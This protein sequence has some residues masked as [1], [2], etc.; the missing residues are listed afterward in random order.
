MA[1]HL[2]TEQD[3]GLE[4]ILGQRFMQRWGAYDE[5]DGK[6]SINNGCN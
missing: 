1:A 4:D 5:T 6:I 2:I 3:N